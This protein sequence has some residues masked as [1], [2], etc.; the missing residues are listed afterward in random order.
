MNITPAQRRSRL[1]DHAKDR[2]WVEHLD[3]S[4]HELV[5]WL[6]TAQHLRGVDMDEAET[7][8]WLET[9]LARFDEVYFIH[10]KHPKFEQGFGPMCAVGVRI[11]GKNKEPHVEWFPWATP[12]NILRCAV[13]FFM[14]HRR[15]GT[16]TMKI[17]SLEKDKDFYFRLEKYCPLFFA[18]KIPDGDPWGRGTEYRFYIKG[19]GE[20]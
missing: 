14:L 16:G 18:G 6:R 5:K 13:S 7:I 9:K 11:E 19:R 3:K 10:D 4:D 20:R 1:Y 17:Y 8:D 2:P 15:K 12:R